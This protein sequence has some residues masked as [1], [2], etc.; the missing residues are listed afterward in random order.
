[1]NRE[2]R[3]GCEINLKEA[4][5]KFVKWKNEE[6]N[7]TEKKNLWAWENRGRLGDL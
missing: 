6:E 2:V 1:M 7:V 4:D 3:S 5:A